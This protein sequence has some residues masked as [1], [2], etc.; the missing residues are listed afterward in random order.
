MNRE[1][2]ILTIAFMNIQGQTKLPLVKQVQIED[3]VKQF[4]IDILHIQEIEICDETFS[5]CNFLSTAFNILSN[6]SDN[7]YGTASLI[8][9]DLE[10]TNVKCDTSGRAIVFN[11]G[12]TTF[13]NFY[14]H[15]GTDNI[16]RSNRENFFSE[17]VPSLL[18][19]HGSSGCMGGDLNSITDKVDANNH[20]A[21][22]MSPSFKRQ[23]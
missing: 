15:S 21:A 10:Y 7:G 14:G 4:N 16:S 23:L 18:P 11:I 19:N 3:F 6:N 8:R 9:S 2:S 17:T 1:N 12:D 13:G 5:D 20:P 22:K